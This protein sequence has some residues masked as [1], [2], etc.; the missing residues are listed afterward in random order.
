[1]WRNSPAKTLT[2]FAKH[3]K[4]AW[5]T[6]VYH[7][8]VK[9]RKAPSV[10]LE[11]THITHSHRHRTQQRNRRQLSSLLLTQRTRR[12][13]L[14]TARLAAVF[15]LRPLLA[16]YPGRAGRQ[17]RDRALQAGITVALSAGEHPA[18]GG[19]GLAAPAAG[20]AAG[21]GCAGSKAVPSRTVE[22]LLVSPG[23]RDAELQPLQEGDHACGFVFPG[24]SPARACVGRRSRG[25]WGY[26]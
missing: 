17:V 13:R 8:N 18:A 12:S 1:M 4:V 23:P 14:P 10:F 25:G 26:V 24:V 5:K 20:G 7:G 3:S 16:E 6:P 2:S 19:A 21:G 9:T 15:R 22:A 11:T